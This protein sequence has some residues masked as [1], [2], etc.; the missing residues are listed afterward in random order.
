MAAAGLRVNSAHPL[1][2]PTPLT[3]FLELLAIIVVPMAQ[4]Y[5]FGLLVA[6][7][8]H[9]WCLFNVMLALFVMS[10]VICWYYEAKPNPVTASI[11]PNMEGKEQR[12]GVMNST[13]W[14]S[15]CTA[16]DNGSVNSMHD[17]YQPLADADAAVEHPHRRSTFRRHRPAGCIAC[18][19][20][21]ASRCSSPG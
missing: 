13:L 5:M 16:I 3:N 18:F 21:S 2:N 12:I 17:S 15:A 9:A 1:E 8:K 7:K 6:N 20:M 14:A 11:L 4:V 19:S 10:F